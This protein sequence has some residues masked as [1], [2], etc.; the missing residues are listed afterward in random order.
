MRWVNVLLLMLLAG[1]QAQLW[2]GPNGLGRVAQQQAELDARE[3]RNAAMR[4]RNARLLAE[5]RDLREGLEMVE[6]RAR[7]ELGM[8]RPDELM[9]QFRPRPA[10]PP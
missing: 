5:V 2:L 1:V 4:E 6:E 7:V 8:V 10:S 9:V 3:A